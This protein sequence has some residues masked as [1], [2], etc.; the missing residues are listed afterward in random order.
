M[1]YASLHTGAVRLRVEFIGRL[2]RSHAHAN[3][4]EHLNQYKNFRM[5]IFGENRSFFG[6]SCQFR[7]LDGRLQARGQLHRHQRH[8]VRGAVQRQQRGRHALLHQLADDLPFGV[9]F[10]R[11]VLGHLR[12][13]GRGN[14]RLHQPPP[15]LVPGCFEQP[16]Q[17]LL[18]LMAFS[19]VTLST[20]TW[21][22]DARMGNVKGR[23]L[24]RL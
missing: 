10:Q 4:E 13:N 14:G 1:L 19:A 17:G 15:V 2:Q 11:V 23:R 7:V 20:V 21:I 18:Q 22:C 8:P 9:K 24:Q 3:Y 12:A 16:K 5:D 6:L